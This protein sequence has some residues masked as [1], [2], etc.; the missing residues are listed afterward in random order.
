MKDKFWVIESQDLNESAKRAANEFLADKNFIEQKAP[1]TVDKYRKTLE[2]FLC[3]CRKDLR[4]ITANDVSKWLETNY[5][6]K[7]EN[8]INLVLSVLSSFFNFCL[9][10]EYLDKKPYKRRWR[11][12]LGRQLPKYFS[13]FDITKARIQSQKMLLRD[14]AL[15]EFLLVS[16]CRRSEAANLNLEKINLEDRTAKVVGKGAKPRT[17]FFTEGCALLLSKYTKELPYKRGPLFVNKFG[18]RLSDKGIYQII[19]KIGQQ[20]GISES[21]SPHRLRHSFATN[22]LAKGGDLVAIAAFLGH[23]SLS[24]TQNYT[25]I[26][27]DDII[28]EYEKRMEY[29]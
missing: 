15:L 12:K 16:G 17:V 26:M 22:M 5:S 23:L 21:F 8:T 4:Q 27:S 7:R 9:R 14:R 20:A 24:T 2:R 28:Y 19:T 1:L 18:S 29:Q 6:D 10:E 13:D 11:P 3:D 25:H